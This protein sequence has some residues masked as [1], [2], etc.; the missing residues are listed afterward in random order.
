MTQVAGQAPW[1]P[2]YAS[3]EQVAEDPK[4]DRFGYVAVV[5]N[6][7][8]GDALAMIGRTGDAL[9]RLE[10]ARADVPR[11]LTGPTGSK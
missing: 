6:R 10:R 9:A 4:S 7:R 5:I 3:P 11:Y 8:I 2:D 1:T